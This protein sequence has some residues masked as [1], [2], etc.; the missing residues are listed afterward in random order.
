LRA[1]AFE[2]NLGITFSEAIGDLNIINVRDE[3][4]KI[5]LQFD[6]GTTITNKR[7]EMDLFDSEDMTISMYDKQGRQMAEITISPDDIKYNPQTGYL[8]VE[9]EDIRID[10]D[11]YYYCSNDEDEEKRK[12]TELE[13]REIKLLTIS[14]IPE[15]LIHYAV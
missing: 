5:V 12:L 3:S 8:C 13:A 6:D 7:Y 14:R 1:I 9:P 10:Y 15:N 2:L 4:Y 11:Y